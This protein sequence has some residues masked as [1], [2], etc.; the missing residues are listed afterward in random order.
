MDPKALTNLPYLPKMLIIFAGILFNLIF[1]YAILIYY[2]LRNQSTLTATISTVTPNSPADQAGLHPD[3]IIIACNHQT[4]DGQ[5]NLITKIVAAYA[6]QTIPFTIERDGITQEISVTLD[7][8]HPLFGSN[9]GWLGIELQK[10]TTSQPSLH[11]TLKKGHTQFTSTIQEM[12]SALSKM[13]TNKGQ[14]NMIMGPIGIISMIGKSLAINP[15]LYWF[16]LAILSLNM[17]LFNILPLPFFDGGQAFIITI[18]A[19][20]GKTIPATALWLVS[21][22]FLTLFFLFMTR[23]TMNDI[24]RLI[25]KK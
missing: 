12:S 23:V 9:V 7:S 25:G 17:G 18:E 10:Q 3:D 2:A 24:K 19:I 1:A 15:Q 21:T 22:V 13:A 8:E 4:I 16:I 11:N 6:Q 20:T 14:K 5:G